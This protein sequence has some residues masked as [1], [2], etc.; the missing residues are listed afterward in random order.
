M[1]E[2]SYSQAST[3]ECDWHRYAVG[4]VAGCRDWRVDAAVSVRLPQIRAMVLQSFGALWLPIAPTE[5]SRGQGHRGQLN[6]LNAELDC[7]V[8]KVAVAGNPKARVVPAKRKARK[9][10]KKR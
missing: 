8:D 10:A 9:E 5:A 4:V 1:T 6:R 7:R 2:A 3:I